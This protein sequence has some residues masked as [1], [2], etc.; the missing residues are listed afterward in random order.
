MLRRGIVVLGLVLLA[1][2]VRADQ[3]HMQ[4]A[5]DHLRRAETA[6]Q[7]AKANKGGHREN[8]LEQIKKAIGEVERGMAAG[9][10]DD[11]PGKH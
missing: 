6:L 4:R 1:A 11:K 8:A 5:L 9:A 10:K 3:P 7:A 2:T